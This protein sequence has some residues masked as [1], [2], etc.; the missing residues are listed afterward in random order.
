MARLPKKFFGEQLHEA[1]QVLATIVPNLHVYVPARPLLTGEAVDAD[2]SS[3]IGQAGL[4]ALGWSLALLA[5]ASFVF[6][7]RDFV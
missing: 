2:L 6:R 5:L 3:Y 4:M 7:R 1:G